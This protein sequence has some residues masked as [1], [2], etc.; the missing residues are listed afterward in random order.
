MYFENNFDVVCI[1][2]YLFLFFYFLFLHPVL[3]V[4]LFPV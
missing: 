4:V 2:F 3:E 1:Q